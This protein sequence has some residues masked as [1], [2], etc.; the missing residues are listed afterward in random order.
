MVA[1]G[2]RAPLASAYALCPGAGWKALRRPVVSGWNCRAAKPAAPD[3]HLEFR[4]RSAQEVSC[5]V[6]HAKRKGQEKVLPLL[7]CVAERRSPASTLRP[8]RRH[9]GTRHNRGVPHGTTLRLAAKYGN[10]C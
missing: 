9:F 6:S 5:P 8:S 7:R 3:L 2:D 4:G 10:N 1:P